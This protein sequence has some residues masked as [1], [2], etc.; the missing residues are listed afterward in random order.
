MEA[1]AESKPWE[2]D[3]YVA[4]IAWRKQ[5]CSLPPGTKLRVGFII[6][7]GVVKPQPPVARA[8]QQVVGALEAAGH[9]GE[10]ARHRLF[11][12]PFG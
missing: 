10:T 6:D 8:V 1:L 12:R 3:P 9:E 4:P 5:D 11:K 7:D 2:S